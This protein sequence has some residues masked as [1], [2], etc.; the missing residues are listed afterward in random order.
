MN[1]RGLA[2]ECAGRAGWPRCCIT[3]VGTAAFGVV[4]DWKEMRETPSNLRLTRY[5][6]VPYLNSTELILFGRVMIRLSRLA[7]YGVV[8]MTQMAGDRDTVHTAQTMADATGL[9]LPTVSKLLSSLG[10]AE[11]LVATRGA[12]GGYKLARDASQITIGDIISAVDG[13]IAITQCIERGPGHCDVE[14]VCR[15]R[16]GF[17]VINDAVR[18]AFA[19]VSLTDLIEPALFACAPEAL[20]SRAGAPAR[21]SL[22]KD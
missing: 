14:Q 6:A 13:P 3:V 8:L 1:P 7:D 18:R 22:G 2:S 9:P 4:A 16:A 5:D 10:R 17:W 15:T 21:A 19:S 12:R 20:A 11:I